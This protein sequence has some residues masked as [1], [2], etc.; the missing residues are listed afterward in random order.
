[1]FQRLIARMDL[2]KIRLHDLRHT[3]NTLLLNSGVP[4]KVVSERLGHGSGVYDAGLP[5]RP[6]GK[7]ADAAVTFGEIGFRSDLYFSGGL[8]VLL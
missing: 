6:P 1:M 2:P 3:H 4:T 8:K 5:T 7:Q